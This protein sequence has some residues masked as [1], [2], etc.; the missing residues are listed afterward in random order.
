[1]LSEIS[2]TKKDKYCMILYVESKK[3]QQ[4]HR[5]REQT[6]GYQW[7]VRS[8]IGMGEWEVQSTGCKV[9]SRRY[10]TAQGI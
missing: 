5:H 1:M 6:S 4:N 9:D 8:N 7:E 10:C 3:I 2:Q